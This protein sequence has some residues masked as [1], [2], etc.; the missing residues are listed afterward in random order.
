MPWLDGDNFETENWRYIEAAN[1]GARRTGPVR[2]EVLHTPQTGEGQDTAIGV[3]NYFASGKTQG[4]THTVVDGGTNGDNII[5]CV[6]DS[7]VCHGAPGANHDRLHVEMAGRAE[8]TRAQ[9][10]DDYSKRTMEFAANVTAQH[11]LKFG[12][13]IRRIGPGDLRLGAKGICDHADVRDAFGKTTHWDVGEGF[14][15]DW[16]LAAANRW[17]HHWL[18]T[19]PG[20]NP[21]PDEPD[22]RVVV[23]ADSDPGA[24]VDEGM[25]RVYAKHNAL[26]FMEWPFASVTFGAAIV[27]GAARK[28]ADEIEAA[29]M[30][31][32]VHV[33]AGKDR[34]ATAAKVAAEI[35]KGVQTLKG[36]PY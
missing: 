34:D 1:Y 33:I 14:P 26:K 32:K 35:G 7:F 11:A 17:H 24:D 20:Y 21:E 27:V 3:A 16:F 10:L 25:G 15:W 12:F 8:Q 36:F 19:H 23:I 31:G 18:S 28:H 2:G 30:E 6:Y 5:Q 13:P 22:F 4:S 9:W 29:A